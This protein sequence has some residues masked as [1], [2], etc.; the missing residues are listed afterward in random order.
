MTIDADRFAIVRGNELPQR[1]SNVSERE[2]VSNAERNNPV[3]KD[4]ILDG[5]LRACGAGRIASKCLHR[6]RNSDWRK[7]RRLLK[8]SAAWGRNREHNGI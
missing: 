5:A 7:R 2:I 4:G 1:A 6:S 3:L 8:K